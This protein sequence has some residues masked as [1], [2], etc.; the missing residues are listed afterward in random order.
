M[1]KGCEVELSATEA[2]KSLE[3]MSVDSSY[4]GPPPLLLLFSD[5][6]AVLLANDDTPDPTP[7]C[8]YR[9]QSD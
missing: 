8:P 9:S 4:N 2:L 1:C 7:S 3:E 6:P 5:A